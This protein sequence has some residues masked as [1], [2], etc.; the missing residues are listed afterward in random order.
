M[1]RKRHPKRVTAWSRGWALTLCLANSKE[2]LTRGFSP[3]AGPA[4]GALAKGKAPFS[5]LKTVRE[6]LERAAHL[7]SDH[8]GALGDPA[9][10][11]SGGETS[12]TPCLAW[13][14]RANDR[15]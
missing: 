14:P 1:S 8:Q 6:P 9:R 3:A 15:T 7:R 4:Q 12:V 10:A 2:T 13:S 11:T 5:P